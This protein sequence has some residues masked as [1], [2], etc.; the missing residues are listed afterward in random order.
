MT[1]IEKIYSLENSDVKQ[2]LIEFIEENT[3][4]KTN[5]LYDAERTNDYLKKIESKNESTNN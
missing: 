1:L 5:R 4:P 2:E 3:C